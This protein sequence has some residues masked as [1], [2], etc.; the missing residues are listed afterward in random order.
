MLEKKI[1]KKYDIR[2]IYP[3]EINEEAVKLVVRTFVRFLKTGPIVIGYDARLSSPKLF[4][5]VKEELSQWPK[6]KIINIGLATA[7][8]LYFS[9]I[10]S[11]ANGGLI[12]TASH[13]PKEYN[14]LKMI[15]RKSEM[16][17]GEKIWALI[18]KNNG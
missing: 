15:D 9:V 1:F 18:K 12:V 8:F 7:P 13:N 2:G 11:Q 14:G 17:S 4:E 16:I 5:A 10:D 6:F 3:T